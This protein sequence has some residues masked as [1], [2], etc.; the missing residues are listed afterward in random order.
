MTSVDCLM[1][2]LNVC[3]SL[4]EDIAKVHVKFGHLVT[5]RARNRSHD[6][7]VPSTLSPPPPLSSPGVYR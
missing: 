1:P 6:Y 2:V 4:E 7:H 3:V 5:T